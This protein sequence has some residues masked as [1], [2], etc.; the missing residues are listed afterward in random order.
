MGRDAMRINHW[1][2]DRAPAMHRR[3]GPGS[4]SQMLWMVELS[5]AGTDRSQSGGYCDVAFLRDILNL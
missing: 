5:A 4:G 3:Q 2:G 1:E